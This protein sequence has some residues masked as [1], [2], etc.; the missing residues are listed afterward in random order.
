MS[1]ADVSSAITTAY[2]DIELFIRAN[3]AWAP[4]FVGVLA[5]CESLAIVSFFVPATG[6]LLAVGAL[7]AVG[8]IA[9]LPMW[10]AAAAGAVFGDW[11]SYAVGLYFKE[12]IHRR[13]PLARYPEFMGRAETFMR[14]W[15]AWGVFIGRFSGPLRAFVPLAAGVFHLSQLRFQAANISSAAIWSF[16]VLAPGQAVGFFSYLH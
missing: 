11:L 2:A 16:V 12:D 9:L 7:A 6:I 13:W 8:E 10:A 1:I 4:L 5:F 15:G 14:R 3:A